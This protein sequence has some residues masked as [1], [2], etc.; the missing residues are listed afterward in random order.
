MKMNGSSAHEQARIW[1]VDD[2]PL[3]SELAR[4]ALEPMHQ[5]EMFVDGAAV[6]EQLSTHPPPDALVLDRQ[7]PGITGIE[8]CQ[9]LRSNPATASLPVLMLT[10]HQE[11]RDLVQGLSAGADDF[12]TKPY[13]AA[14]LSA[15]IAAMIRSKRTFDR[16]RGRGED[17][18]RAPAPS[19][20]GRP[21]LQSRRARGDLREPRGRGGVLAR[22]ERAT[23][24]GRTSPRCCRGS[25][26][27]CMLEKSC[28]TDALRPPRSR[29]ERRRI[30]A[31]VASV[32]SRRADAEWTP[33]SRF[34]TSR[35]S[36]SARRA[37]SISTLSSAHDLRAP[38]KGTMMMRADL[39]LGGRRGPLPPG[40]AA[41]VALMKQ[42]M[43][44]LVAMVS[45][46]LDLARLENADVEL[47]RSTVD[48]RDLV[49][50][51]VEDFDPLA[52]NKGV[53]LAVDPRDEPLLVAAD[54]RRLTQVLSNLLSNAIKFSPSSATVSVRFEERGDDIEVQVKDAGPGIDP[55]ALPK[56]FTRYA[57]ALDANHTVSGTGLG[58][59]IVKQ[60][61][62]AHGG[63]V[64]VAS[65]P[66]VGSTFAFSLPR[67]GRE[68]RHAHIGHAGPDA[69]LLRS[70]G[71]HVLVVDDD[72]G[73]L[74]EM[75]ALRAEGGAGYYVLQAEN[76]RVALR[77]ASP[78]MPPEAGRPCLLGH[79][80]AEVMSG[81][82]LPRDPR[83]T[84]GSP[85]RSP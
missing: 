41:D 19:A 57:R 18:P 8:V 39:L 52:V 24:S 70:P 7:M 33:P 28:R 67:L 76:G 14:E 20:R 71:R 61:V 44:D 82:E 49:K 4:R 31:P 5:V 78:R 48:Q 32:S 55:A 75:M 60:L 85:P 15:R 77:A 10:T 2:S 68:A 79:R 21:H 46:F 56:L 73:D 38:L 47:V 23:W 50:E 16:L 29:A 25:R 69:D 1:I 51:V 26:G 9:F 80:H 36:A 72:D 6:L 11:T 13:N 65:E 37:G 22:R 34:A 84:E 74:R 58:L 42:R 43:G 66:G 27:P 30:L 59:M 81:T 83:W 54:R 35:S 62:E 3:E 17:R 64:R 63:G 45:D 53:T 40:V 12:L